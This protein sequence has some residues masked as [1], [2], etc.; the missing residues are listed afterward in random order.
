M[1]LFLFP[2]LSIVLPLRDAPK[3]ILCKSK[4]GAQA[5]IR[6]G[7]APSGPSVATALLVGLKRLIETD[8]QIVF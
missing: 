3:N 2:V 5:V 7:T 6:G 1:L 8:W 4:W